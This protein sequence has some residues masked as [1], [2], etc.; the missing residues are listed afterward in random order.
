MD[1]RSRSQALAP[2]VMVWADEDS[3]G[4]LT[5]GFASRACRHSATRET[6]ESAT[7]TKF[8]ARALS[9]RYLEIPKVHYYS[10]GYGTVQ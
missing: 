3:R 2:S 9:V 6:S 8:T 1:S 4:F 10:M 7:G 5:P